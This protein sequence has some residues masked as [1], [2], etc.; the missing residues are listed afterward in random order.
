LVCVGLLRL[1]AKV[2]VSLKK[3][4]TLFAWI[5]LLAGL[6]DAL[7]N[8]HLIQVIIIGSGVTHGIL[9][10]I[11]SVIKFSILGITLAWLVFISITYGWRKN[12]T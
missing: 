10:S 12:N 5:A 9:A 6:A 4:T 11:F 7:E 8:Y 1:V 3:L 2:P